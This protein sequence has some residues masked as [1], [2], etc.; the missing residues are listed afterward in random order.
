VKASTT[1]RR[2][3]FKGSHFQKVKAHVNH[4]SGPDGAC[5]MF[6]AYDGDG[7]PKGIVI[8]MTKDE[9]RKLA[10]ALMAEAVK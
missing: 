8:E 1:W 3:P 10:E 5:I 6:T 2:F 7:L 9:A 4:V